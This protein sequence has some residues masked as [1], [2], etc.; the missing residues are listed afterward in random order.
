MRTCPAA[1]G[2]RILRGIGQLRQ[3]LLA[4]E[5]D[6]PNAFESYHQ[7]N[8]GSLSRYAERFLGRG[9]GVAFP[10]HELCSTLTFLSILGSKYQMDAWPRPVGSRQHRTTKSGPTGTQGLRQP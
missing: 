4:R 2:T 3:R 9:G 7:R 10:G 8:A 5:E 6:V 1:Q